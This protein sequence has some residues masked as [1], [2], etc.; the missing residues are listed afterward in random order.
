MKMVKLSSG[1]VILTHSQQ[2]TSRECVTFSPNG[3]FF[4]AGAHNDPHVGIFDTTT[5]ELRGSVSLPHTVYSLSWSHCGRWLAA[6]CGD[7]KAHIIDT[8]SY[9]VAAVLAG[10]ANRIFCLQW[11]PL[12]LPSSLPNPATASSTD[13]SSSSLSASFNSVAN[14]RLLTASRDCTVRVWKA[15]I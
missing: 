15:K 2:L 12:L 7:T 11:K 9:A 14:V 8:S 1:E 6:G 5:G 3:S 10:H 13:A 4:A